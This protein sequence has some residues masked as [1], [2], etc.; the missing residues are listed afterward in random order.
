MAK[1]KI[2]CKGGLISGSFSVWLRSPKNV[3][4][5]N[6]E[7]YPPTKTMLTARDSDLAPFSVGLKVR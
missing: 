2:F 4:F 6:P 3:P 1:I 7:H 5:H